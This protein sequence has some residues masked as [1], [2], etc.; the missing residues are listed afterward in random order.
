MLF[1]I[2]TFIKQFPHEFYGRKLHC[3]NMYN[4]SLYNQ[5]IQKIDEI[6]Y[7]QAHGADIKK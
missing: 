5:H 2:K 7:E 1:Q 3:S 4:K 6:I